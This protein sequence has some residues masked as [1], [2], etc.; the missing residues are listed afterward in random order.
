MTDRTDNRL[1]GLTEAERRIMGN[2]LRQSPEQH[3]AAPKPSTPQ[4]DA[5]RRRRQKEK[6]AAATASQDA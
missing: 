5:Q 6:E 4:G 2:L 3:K 1:R